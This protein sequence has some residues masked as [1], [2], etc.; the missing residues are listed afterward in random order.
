MLRCAIKLHNEY[1][2][3]KFFHCISGAITYLEKYLVPTQKRKK[4]IVCALQFLKPFTE[5]GNHVESKY[6]HGKG[7]R[8]FVDKCSSQLTLIMDTVL[9]FNVTDERAKAKNPESWIKLQESKS[10]RLE[11]LNENW[12]ILP[13]LNLLETLKSEFQAEKKENNQSKQ[14]KKRKNSKIA[15]TPPCEYKVVTPEPR[16]CKRQ[17]IGNQRITK[18]KSKMKA[19][20][21]ANGKKKRKYRDGKCSSFR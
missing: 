11:E 4:Q 2:E 7:S 1:F 3:N 5:S 12:L 13:Q 19:Q 18:A 20:L 8:K 14:S 16:T 6:L 17:K 21:T 9:E 15:A 10:S